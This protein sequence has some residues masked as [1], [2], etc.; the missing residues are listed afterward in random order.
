MLTLI[1]A[2]YLLFLLLDCY[3]LKQSYTSFSKISYL[4]SIILSAQL[5]SHSYILWE[6]PLLHFK[7]ISFHFTLHLNFRENVF[8]FY[9]HFRVR[10]NFR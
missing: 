2:M 3:K 5:N 4:N 6:L 10:T 8:S 9:V 1:N 7:L